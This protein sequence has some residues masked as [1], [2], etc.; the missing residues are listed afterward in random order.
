MKGLVRAS[1]PKTRTSSRTCTSAVVAAWSRWVEQILVSAVVEGS[2]V[3]MQ[4]TL[5]STPITF[6]PLSGSR[7][8]SLSVTSK[9]KPWWETSGPR[10]TTALPADTRVSAPTW[11]VGTMR[12]LEWK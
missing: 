10:A 7:S 2:R 4:A 5:R 6:S 3:T 8:S 1:G 12:W 9:M 11:Q